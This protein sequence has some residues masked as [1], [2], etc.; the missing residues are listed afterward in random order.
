MA[1]RNKWT[2]FQAAHIFPRALRS[3]WNT[4]NFGIE[5]ID[6]VQNGLLLDAVIHQHFDAFDFSVDTKVMNRYV[7]PDIQ[8]E[9]KSYL[10]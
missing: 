1:H 9:L 3:S 4:Y 6:S 2:G 10:G 5:G 8:V 7:L